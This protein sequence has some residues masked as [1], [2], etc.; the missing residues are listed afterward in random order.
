MHDD[1]HTAATKALAAY[2]ALYQEVA[3]TPARLAELGNEVAALD[4]R[5]RAAAERLT[6]DNDPHAY[7]GQLLRLAHDKRS[8]DA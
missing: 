3:F 5:M 4:A 6:F 1:Q 7:Q 2:L 8:N